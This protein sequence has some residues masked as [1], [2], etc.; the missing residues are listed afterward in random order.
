MSALSVGLLGRCACGHGPTLCTGATRRARGEIIR[1]SRRAHR[2][3]DRHASTSAPS[4]GEIK[5][6]RRAVAA[7]RHR[8]RHDR[9][10]NPCPARSASPSGYPPRG[11]PPDALRRARLVELTRILGRRAARGRRARSTAE[12]TARAT[13]VAGGTTASTASSVTTSTSSPPGHACAATDTIAGSSFPVRTFS[14]RLSELSVLR[15]ISTFGWS[16]WKSASS[17]GDVDAV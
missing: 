10:P 3:D 17:C 12:P 1:A 16:A 7:P 2:P 4:S 11:D 13:R 5:T 14:M 15:V 9:T 8:L 6:R